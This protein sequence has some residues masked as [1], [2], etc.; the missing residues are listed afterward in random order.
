MEGCLIMLCPHCRKELPEDEVLNIFY[1]WVKQ[2]IE[3]MVAQDKDVYEAEGFDILQA[4]VTEYEA[5]HTKEKCPRNADTQ[6]G[7]SNVP[8][9]TAQVS[10]REHDV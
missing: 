9:A 4:F 2:A 5:E 8:G 7:V 3:H 6:D 10:K 1:R